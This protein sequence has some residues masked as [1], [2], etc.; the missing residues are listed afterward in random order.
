MNREAISILMMF[1]GL[2]FEQRQSF[3]DQVVNEVVEGIESPTQVGGAIRNLQDILEAIQTDIKKYIIE[4]VERNGG[5][6]TEG[7]VSFQIKEGGV[8]W[9]YSNTND[10]TLDELKES[11]ELAAKNYK[12][13]EGFL[14]SLPQGGVE[15]IDESTGEVKKILPPIKSSTTTVAISLSK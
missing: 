3:H 8:K 12:E 10:F 9:D 6:Y 15:V 11:L 13:R 7:G 14:K 5:N 2:S 4:E 1:K